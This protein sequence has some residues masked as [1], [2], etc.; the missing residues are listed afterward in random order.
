M[1][2]FFSKLFGGKSKS[3]GGEVETLVQS[4]LTGIIEKGQFDL[5]FKISYEKESDADGVLS[6]EFSGSDEEMLKDKK[7]QMLDAFQ[8]F[9]KRVV[10][11]NFPEDK[12]NITVDC[13]GYRD[14]S[15]AA[16]IERAENLKTIAIEQG[17]S[18]YYRALPPKDRKVVHQY[19]AQDPRVKSRS[20]GEGLYKKIKIYPAKGTGGSSAQN[21]E[22]AGE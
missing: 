16:L 19:L 2:G 6:I 1:A 8:L 11:H 13:G 10:Q 12:T 18:V 17:K 15:A 22:A 14:E 21:Q 4:T 3:S 9:L 20:L 5:S 7:G